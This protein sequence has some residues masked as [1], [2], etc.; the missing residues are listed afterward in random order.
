MTPESTI[1]APVPLILSPE[2]PIFAPEPPNLASEPVSLGL[3]VPN[4]GLGPSNPGH[5]PSYLGGGWQRDG[6]FPLSEC[7]PPSFPPFQK[8]QV[9]EESRGV[10]KLVHI[11]VC[12]PEFQKAALLSSL[13]RC[14]EAHS[15]CL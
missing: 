14:K 13:K 2:P 5:G 6:K 11:S 10:L 7:I 9:V 1:L 3:G 4:I 8:C 12:D 15:P